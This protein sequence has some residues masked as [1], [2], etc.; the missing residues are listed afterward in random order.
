MGV[1]TNIVVRWDP[2][3]GGNSNDVISFSLETG[4]G[5][6]VVFQTPTIPGV[7]G[8]LNGTNN[9]VVIPA[10]TLLPGRLYTAKLGFGKRMASTVSGYPGAL[11]ET[12]YWR[13]TQFAIST[14]LQWPTSSGGNG[15]WYEAVMVAASVTW[16]NAQS[17]AAGRHGHLAT[18]SSGAENAFVH[19]LV[20]SDTNFWRYD[21]ARTQWYGPWLEGISPQA[22][23]SP[24]EAGSG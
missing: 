9:A 5:G 22:H 16:S 2:M 19:G 8:A 23:P 18:I 20:S 24:G 7:P 13:N 11:G 4:V 3:V 10:N 17:M 12:S 15:H 21:S 1:S 14:A 6:P